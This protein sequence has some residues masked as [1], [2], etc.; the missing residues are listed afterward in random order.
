MNALQSARLSEL[1]SG[2][3]RPGSN[4]GPKVTSRRKQG[5][6]VVHIVTR[7]LQS[8]GLGFGRLRLKRKRRM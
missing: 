4:S 1:S 7:G 3:F 6:E 2:Y 8:H 5:L